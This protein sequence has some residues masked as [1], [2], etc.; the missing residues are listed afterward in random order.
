MNIAFDRANLLCG[1]IFIGFAVFFGVQSLGME[2]GEAVRMGPGYL[3]LLLSVVLGVLGVVII[4]QAAQ[5][6]GEPIGP[7]A[8][9]G[10]LFIL[11]APIVF[12]LTVRGFGF[13]PALFIT[14]L[15]AAFASVMMRPSR[16]LLLAVII[17]VFSVIVFSYG[18]GLPFRRFGPWIEFL[19][20]R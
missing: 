17:T 1:L 16:A 15:I 5:F 20:L 8:W 7:L 4:V 9:R 11:P 12:A 6:K 14:A 2:I 3:P 19:G 18:L 13:V 10:M